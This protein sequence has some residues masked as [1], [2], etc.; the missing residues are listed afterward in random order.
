MI[1]LLLLIAIAGAVDAPA[2]GP[3][4]PEVQVNTVDG[5]VVTGQLKQIYKGEIELATATLSLDEVL[6]VLP[7]STPE[8]PIE[9][10]TTWIE[11]IDGSKFTATEFSIQGG[12]VSLTL[13]TG[14]TAAGTTATLH[15]VRFSQPGESIAVARKYRR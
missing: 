9:K 7:V 4:G 13:G 12:A 1:G 6:T 8:P 15:R 10:P 2:S 5:R 3:S 14:R 11:L